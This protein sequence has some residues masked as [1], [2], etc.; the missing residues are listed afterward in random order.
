M[1]V[2]IVESPNKCRTIEKYLGS[3]Y[4]VISTKGHVR[5]LA[6]SGKNGLG[7]DC[8][9]DFKPTYTIIKG[10]K[11]IVEEIKNIS[12]SADEVILATDPD[13]EG[14]A[15][16]WHLSE[17]LKLKK[18]N[19]R[20]E[21]HEITR[22]SIINA[23]NNPR[24]ID[25]KLVASQEVRRIV[26]RI[27]GFR[28]SNVLQK[29]KNLKSAGRVQ[30]ATLRLIIDHEK[31][32]SDFKPIKYWIINSI[33]KK[34]NKEI[35]TDLYK[36]KSKN[37]SDVK[38]ES[39]EL[40][41]E[42][43]KETKKNK[44]LKV[45]DVKKK[46]KTINSKTPFITST[47]QQDAITKLNMSA[48]KISYILQELYEG[49]KIK[50]EIVGLITYI[51]TD[52]Q[53]LS[54]SYIEDAKKYIAKKY[55]DEYVKKEEKKIKKREFAQNAHEAI[56]P[57]NN[58]YDPESIKKFLT[59]D[60]YKLYKLIYN[61]TLGY[62]MVG[63]KEEIT[64]VIIGN[65]NVSYK[66]YGSKLIYCGFEIL[67]K[68]DLKKDKELGFD[69]NINDVFNVVDVQLKYDFTKPPSHLT[70]ASVIKLMEE[71]GIGRPSTYS[72]I[73]TLLQERLYVIKD[74]NS[75]IPTDNGLEVIK[76]LKSKFPDI[77]NIDFT[78]KLESDLDK[79]DESK[80]SRIDTIN[81]IYIP[82]VKEL[83][84]ALQEKIGLCPICNS[85]LIRVRGKNGKF[86][87]GCSNFPKCKY[88]KKEPKEKLILL[89]RKCPKCNEFLVK[90]MNKKGKFF[91]GCSGFPKCHYIENTNKNNSS[92]K[93]K[94]EIKNNE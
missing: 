29:M 12:K 21:F 42:I 80:K 49:I 45:L 11:K 94:K 34:D 75:I 86:F 47:L 53:N 62:L 22:D 15:I 40:A 27:I 23:I 57:I 81:K 51:R 92:D 69:V 56:R 60:Q 74:K 28:L 39:E 25:L 52:S 77:V 20:L 63:K 59:N 93:I 55:G 13:R 6:I 79:V 76:F 10:K 64:S 54:S 67:N 61:R 65:E 4:K 46:I 50:D 31:K 35:K 26:D 24:F 68:E 82:F 5:D 3:D 43:I 66:I 70:E 83:N 87:T 90:R 9:N 48:S 38:I 73:V 72:K 71:K 36:Y 88:V 37:Y 41:N 89:D 17:I 18:D 58:N 16:A 32:I 1:K 44:V 33:L 19:K 7:V 2:V 84:D 30:S 8:E 85:Q 91:I 14:E 78:A